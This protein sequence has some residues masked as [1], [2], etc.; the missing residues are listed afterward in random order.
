MATRSLHPHAVRVPGHDD[1]LEQLRAELRDIVLADEE[2]DRAFAPQ[3]ADLAIRRWRSFARRNRSRHPAA[4][5]RYRDLV[6]GLQQ[7]Y[8]GEI[9]YVSPGSLEKLAGNFSDVLGRSA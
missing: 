7:G 6:K 4:E 9:I 3:L 5:L 2:L 1:H 8:P